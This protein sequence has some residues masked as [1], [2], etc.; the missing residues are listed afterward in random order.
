MGGSKAG[1]VRTSAESSTWTIVRRVKDR[2]MQFIAVQGP[3][4]ALS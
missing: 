2:S 4:L 1:A 3:G